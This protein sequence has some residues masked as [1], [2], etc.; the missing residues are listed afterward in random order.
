[1]VRR[2]TTLMAVGAGLAACHVSVGPAAAEPADISRR[3]PMLSFVGM[4]VGPA[5]S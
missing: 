4:L 3:L 2:L 5:G 1:M